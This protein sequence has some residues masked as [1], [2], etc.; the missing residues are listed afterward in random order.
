ML[1]LLPRPLSG[2]GGHGVVA[3]T[4]PFVYLSAASSLAAGHCLA[5]DRV[6]G[7]V[8]HHQI[9]VMLRLFFVDICALRNK[10]LEE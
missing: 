9:M 10:A 6:V 8:I 7:V 4:D 1:L 2:G 3:L 5:D